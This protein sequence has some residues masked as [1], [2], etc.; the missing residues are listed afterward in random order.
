MVGQKD[1]T[2]EGGGVLKLKPA[3]SSA[4]AGSGVNLGYMGSYIAELSA[5]IDLSQTSDHNPPNVLRSILRPDMDFPG[6]VCIPHNGQDT[7]R[8][9]SIRF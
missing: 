8:K 2:F 4:G 3:L 5:L 9:I 7:G 6:Q 1:A